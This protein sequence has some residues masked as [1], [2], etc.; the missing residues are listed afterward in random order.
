MDVHDAAAWSSIAPLSEQSVKA[1]SAPIEF[2]DFTRGTR[3][4]RSAS[5][6]ATLA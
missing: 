2:P 6:I 3:N 5:A 1:A 4:K